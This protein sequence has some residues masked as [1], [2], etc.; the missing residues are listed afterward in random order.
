M[1]CKRIGLFTIL[2]FVIGVNADLKRT[3]CKKARN[4][5]ADKNSRFDLCAMQHSVPNLF[6]TKC[7]EEYRDQ[8]YRY[9]DLLA[10]HDSPMDGPHE[11]CSK[12]FLETDRFNLIESHYKSAVDL[13]K[14]AHC[15]S[16]CFL[17]NRFDDLILKL[18]FLR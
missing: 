15:S 11:L 2:Y 7:V 16:R 9:K 18:F 13:W 3:E 12:E 6:C 8:Y 10:A 17:R 1:H 14:S 4:N 5:F